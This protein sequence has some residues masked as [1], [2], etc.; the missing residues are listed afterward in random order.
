MPR[1][2]FETEA[3]KNY[4]PFAAENK[5]SAIQAAIAAPE[6]RQQLDDGGGEKLP[7]L[8]ITPSAPKEQAAEAVAVAAEEPEAPGLLSP[9]SVPQLQKTTTR[10]GGE[11]ARAVQ[12]QTVQKRFRVTEAEEQ[13]CEEY[14]LRMRAAASSKVDFSVISRALWTLVQHAESEVVDLL[15]KADM[16][17]RPGKHDII[18]QAE[19]EEQWVRV[20][21]SALRR[22][23]PVK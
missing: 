17:K 22:A 16:P 9:N 13:Q 4:D 19:Y 15:K 21:S 2:K 20:L 23:T 14:V 11:L 7:S 1:K 6:K 8:T 5:R 3:E 18:A 12:R 10:E